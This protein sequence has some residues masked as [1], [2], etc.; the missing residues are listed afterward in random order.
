VSYHRPLVLR[1]LLQSLEELRPENLLT[2]RVLTLEDD[3]KTQ[4]LVKH[5]SNELPISLHKTA[6]L[7]SPGAS[8]NVLIQTSTA[9]Y[10]C[11]LDD[12]AVCSSSYFQV[13]TRLMQSDIPVF[14]GPDQPL[15]EGDHYQKIIGAVL[16]HP[17][18]MGPTYM[19]HTTRDPVPD[20]TSETQLTLCNLWVKRNILDESQLF[21]N[22]NLKRCEENELLNKLQALNYRLVYEP[23]LF[24]YHRRR[25][26]LGQ[27][28]RIQF[29][30]GFYRGV[31]VYAKTSQLKTF[32]L[33]PFVTGMLLL[34]SPFLPERL[35]YTLIFIH[36]LLCLKVIYKIK[37]H[38]KNIS[39]GIWTWLLIIIIHV[40]FSLGL[41]LGVIL[42][43]T[44][45]EKNH[46]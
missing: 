31:C 21:F 10:L 34:L 33:I 36:G 1:K 13:A 26:Q 42:G 12:D 15:P 5:Y 6:T 30:S 45:Y 16:A 38:I 35:L 46:N 28:A 32:F 9:E 3:E 2:I 7:K 29:L 40:F 43:R 37:E 23:E 4:Q 11:F 39:M 17:L 25:T 8:R 27:I 44:Q 41:F 14:G 22:E 20:I 19:R 18:V 24:V